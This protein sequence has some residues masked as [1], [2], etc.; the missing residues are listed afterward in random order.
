LGL[1]MHHS[2]RDV[3]KFERVTLLYRFATVLQNLYDGNNP[4][5]HTDSTY[6]M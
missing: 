1:E 5:V 4:I 2:L 6:S 3:M